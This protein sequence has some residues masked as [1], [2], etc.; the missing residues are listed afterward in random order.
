[1]LRRPIGKHVKHPR[2][3]PNNPLADLYFV[4]SVERV[5]VIYNL[6]TIE[7]WDWYDWGSQMLLDNQDATKGCWQNGGYPGTSPAIDTCFA[8]LFLKQANLAK[9]LTS[10]LQLLAGGKKP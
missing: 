5:A 7:D 1:M 9:D 2:G 6:K 4:W 8:L 3:N 10:K